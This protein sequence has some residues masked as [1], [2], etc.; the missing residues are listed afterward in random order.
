M[1]YWNLMLR[2]H[3]VGHWKLPSDALEYVMATVHSVNCD[4]RTVAPLFR[5]LA[6]CPVKRSTCFGRAARVVLVF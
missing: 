1:N 2:M 5:E 4:I 6:I 3:D